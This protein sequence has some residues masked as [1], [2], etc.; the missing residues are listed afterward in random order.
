MEICLAN[1]LTLE[2]KLFQKTWICRNARKSSVIFVLLN[3]HSNKYNLKAAIEALE[4]GVKYV[5]S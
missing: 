3:T 2:E 5:E 1:C 4:E